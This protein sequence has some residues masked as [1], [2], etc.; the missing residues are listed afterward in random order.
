MSTYRTVTSVRPAIVS[1]FSTTALMSVPKPVAVPGTVTFSPVL[2]IVRIGY[3]PFDGIVLLYSFYLLTPQFQI[4]GGM[5][6]LVYD[7]QHAQKIQDAG[8]YQQC[9]HM[10]PPSVRLFRLT[11]RPS[12]VLD[13]QAGQSTSAPDGGRLYSS[14]IFSGMLSFRCLIIHFL[15]V[16]KFCFPSHL[17]AV[18]RRFDLL[19]KLIEIIA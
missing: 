12:P 13:R 9:L 1:T 3:V 17:T 2:I 8:Q 4:G 19:Q 11:L 15:S 18:D 5:S 6:D 16:C 7:P 10:P 14:G